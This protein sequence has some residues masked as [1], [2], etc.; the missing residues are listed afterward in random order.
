MKSVKIGLSLLAAASA[1]ALTLAPAANAAPSSATAAPAAAVTAP[2]LIT[3]SAKPPVRVTPSGVHTNADVDGACNSLTNGD[4]DFCL[5]F[6][7]NFVGSLCDRFTSDANLGDNTF[8]TPGLGLGAVVANNSES[9]LNADTRLSVAVFTGVNGT[10]AAGLIAPRGFGNFNPTF[11]NNV[12]S[13][14]FM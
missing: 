6:S 12:E 8:L 3:T 1:L 10:G 4:G 9:A 11:V 13:F 7:T 5:W 14:R 2:A